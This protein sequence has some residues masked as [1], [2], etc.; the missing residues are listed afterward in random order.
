MA[1][2]KLSFELDEEDEGST[3]VKSI[4]A[5]TGDH[6]S[7]SDLRPTKPRLGPNAAISNAP[8]VVTKSTLAKEAQTRSQLRKEF[9][10]IQEALKSTEIL[11]PFVFYD[12]TNI[13]GGM[14]KVKKGDHIWL[15]L[16]NAR[17]V[18]V[19]MGAGGDRSKK[20]WARVGID[21]LM[22]VREEIIIPHVSSEDSKILGRKYI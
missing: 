6:Q 13:P 17:K 7:P 1:R 10:V 11:I 8:K 5:A 3:P 2:G 19:Q 22:L 4:K 12:G 14:C 16:D 15:F 20:E 9:M 18:G 21:D